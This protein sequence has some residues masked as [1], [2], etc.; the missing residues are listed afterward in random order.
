ME[1]DASRCFPN[2]HC[3]HQ[4]K[5]GPALGSFA[6]RRR[7]RSVQD[8]NEACEKAIQVKVQNPIEENI[9]VYE[10]YYEVYT[11][12]YPALKGSYRNYWISAASNQARCQK[13]VEVQQSIA[14]IQYS[15]NNEV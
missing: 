7:C 3:N 9:P 5:E 12:L 10:K 13:R 14:G 4:P 8:V 11:D 6:G 2:T 1:A 15:G